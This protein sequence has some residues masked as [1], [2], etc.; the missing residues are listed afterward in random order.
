MKNFFYKF[1]NW[2]P[3]KYASFLIMI[4]PFFNLVF[5]GFFLDNDFW[6]LCNLGKTIV[7]N[8]FIQTELFTFH[9]GLFF[10]PQQWLTDVIFYYIYNYFGIYGM[11]GLIIVSNLLFI[12]LLNKICSL[13]TNNNK[14]KLF[15]IIFV[16]LLLFNLFFFTRPQL[17][18]IFIIS[19]ELYLLELYVKSNNYKYLF[20]VPILSLLFIN[21]HAS[22]WLLFFVFLV[23]YFVECL[24]HIFLKKKEYSIIPLVIVTVISFIVGFINPYGLEAILY[25]FGSYGIMEINSIVGEM[26]P[27]IIYELIGKILFFIVFVIIYSFYY[28]KGHNKLRYFLLFIGTL[29]LSLSHFKGLL[30]FFV[31][32]P[33]IICYNFKN[34]KIIKQNCALTYEKVIYL[35]LIISMF[36][37]I[38]FFTNIE[39]GNSYDSFVNYLN[40]NASKDIKLY[41]NYDSGNY[42]EFN[43]YKCYI[44]TRAEVFLK[45]NNRKE[46]IFIEYYKLSN[47]LLNIDSF[48]DKYDFDYL[49]VEK[50]M[51]RFL[52]NYLNN[53]DDYKLILSDKI[54]Y[55]NHNYKYYLFENIKK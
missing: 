38:L 29:Y 12:I 26:N 4:L 40:D 41:T 3:S 49:L 46:D 53:S 9:K 5:R 21:L 15:A 22:M 37:Y 2:N 50:S 45:A 32:L 28:N 43:G 42:F 14:L 34:T 31:C 51:D 55:N 54:K 24:F 20:G 1:I 8:G 35:I 6:F 19:L 27:I 48:L 13:Y 30:F 16:D 36:V 7:S 10:I 25:L 18:D 17:F 47:G 33:F 23:P 11:Y 52:Y 39:E 44:D